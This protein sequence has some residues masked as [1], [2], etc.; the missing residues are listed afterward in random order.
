MLI[1]AEI[2]KQG[3]FPF[4][5]ETNAVGP[6]SQRFRDDIGELRKA[7]ANSVFWRKLAL[8]LPAHA[9]IAELAGLRSNWDSYGAP[10]P[11]DVAVQKS[12]RVLSLMSPFDLEVASIVPSA[13][14]GIGFCFA[15]EE[16]YADI[17]V[18]NDGQ[19]LGVRYAGMDAP[20]LIQSDGTDNSIRQALEQVRNHIRA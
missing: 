15:R 7:N 18:S 3:E 14:G 4:W 1:A 8:L 17:E 5:S 11:S 10:A 2:E 13:E 9:R 19:I 16:R 6:A 12:I 20:I